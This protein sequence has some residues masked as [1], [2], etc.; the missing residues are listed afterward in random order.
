MFNNAGN[1]GLSLNFFAFGESALAH[2]SV[3][4]ATSVILMN[5]VG[6]LIASYGS[7]NL[8]NA[9]LELLKTPVVYAVVIALVFNYTGWELPTPVH[10]SVEILADAAIPL[11]MILMGVQLQQSKWTRRVR[12]VGFSTVM[13][14]VGA[15]L[16]ALLV[17]I[18]FRLEGPAR[19]AGISQSA[20]PTAVMMTVLATEYDVEPS[21][22]TMAVVISTLLS[23]LTVTPI[24]AMLG[25]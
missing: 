1:Y 8:K 4:F 13:R 18:L 25:A 17:A 21:F 16:V 23:P 11:M 7:A 15:P 12:A 10:R 3:Y 22:V 20:M 14:L 5:T 24:L 9:L 2:A 19:Q 6:V